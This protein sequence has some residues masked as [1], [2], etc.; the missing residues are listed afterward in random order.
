M[1]SSCFTARQSRPTNTLFCH[2]RLPSM[3]IAMSFLMSML[4][5]A[6]PVS[7]LP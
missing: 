7:W 2:A 6:A 1:T 3:L 4:V 5:K